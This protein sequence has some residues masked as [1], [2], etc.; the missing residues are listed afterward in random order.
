MVFDE[1]RIKKLQNSQMLPSKKVKNLGLQLQYL[2]GLTK[3][4]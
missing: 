1:N 4:S 3:Q 2:K